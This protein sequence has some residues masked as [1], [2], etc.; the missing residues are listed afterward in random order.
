MNTE[1]QSKEPAKTT[2][3]LPKWF[4]VVAVLALAWF[5]MDMSAFVMRAFML[6]ETLKGMPEARRALYLNMPSWVNVVFAAEVLGGMIGSIGLLLRRQW[7]LVGF[8]ISLLGTLSQTAYVYFMS[9]AISIMG[10]PAIVMPLV[11]IAICVAIILVTKSAT[12]KNW[13]K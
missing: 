11:A 13:L 9:D 3:P 6:D 8:G 12:A 5:L 7:A 10:T 2:T 1:S 4:W